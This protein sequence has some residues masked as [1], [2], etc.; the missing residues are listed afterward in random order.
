MI[1][2]SRLW[3]SP[4]PGSA[5]VPTEGHPPWKL[6]PVSHHPPQP[7]ESCPQRA[8]NSERG[9]SYIGSPEQLRQNSL[10]PTTP[11]LRVQIPPPVLAPTK[12]K[13]QNWHR[14]PGSC[15]PSCLRNIAL[16]LPLSWTQLS[17]HTT[18]LCGPFQ[19]YPSLKRVQI[20]SA[21]QPESWG[22]PAL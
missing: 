17:N 10:Y 14:Q 12:V 2:Q 16:E 6:A 5:R 21:V 3:P 19:V 22:D 8:P 13:C 20:L 11:G 7:Q 18:R 1:P 15:L 9:G 4:C